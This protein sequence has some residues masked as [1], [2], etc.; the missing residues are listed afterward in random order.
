MAVFCN[1]IFTCHCT[2]IPQ[3]SSKAIQHTKIGM[4]QLIETGLEHPDQSVVSKWRKKYRKQT[5]N[6]HFILHLVTQNLIIWLENHHIAKLHT[7]LVAKTC[8]KKSTLFGAK[9]KI[10]QILGMVLWVT[11]A[12]RSRNNQFPPQMCECFFFAS[13]SPKNIWHAQLANKIIWAER[14]IERRSSLSASALRWW[15]VPRPPAPPFPCTWPP[16][17]P[18][19]VHFT[20]AKECSVVAWTPSRGICCR[21]CRTLTGNALP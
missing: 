17:Q 19:L 15:K 1:S 5:T 11:S 9:P 3:I 14:G 21:R 6:P 8:K 20:C 13:V 18:P 7:Q 4:A 2:V 10:G 12:A 16:P